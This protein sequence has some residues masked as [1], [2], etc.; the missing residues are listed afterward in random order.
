M[1]QEQI[2]V[3]IN[4]L[5]GKMAGEVLRLLRADER[6]KIVPFGLTGPKIEP[7]VYEGI[8][9]YHQG[10]LGGNVW[11]ELR[12][13]HP[14][15]IAI[16]F[17]QPNAAV[18]N[19][20]LYYNYGINFVMGTTGGDS[21]ELKKLFEGQGVCCAVIAPNMAKPIVL[22]QAMME[23]AADKFPDA[24]AEYEGSAEE[25]HQKGKKDTS[26]TAKAIIGYLQKLGLK[27]ERIKIIM[28]R[29][30]L[31]QMFILGVPKKYLKGHGWHT[32]RLISADKTVELS[33]THNVN[34]RA[35]YAHGTRDAVLF[36]AQK[37]SEGKTGIAYSM[38]DVL[39]G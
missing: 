29:S 23:F 28:R 25:S 2:S 11:Q 34:G 19:A 22:F 15:I 39:G 16:D 17:T 18:N 6:F 26:G 21:E 1:S 10:D 14:N 3:M 24:L 33:F 38:L 4:G 36:L 13:T 32:Y 30:P 8:S 31:Y 37:L 7:Q 35:V 20:R 9:L 27:I 12:D 5:P